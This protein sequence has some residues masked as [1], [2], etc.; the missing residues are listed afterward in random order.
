MRSEA[1]EQKSLVQSTPWKPPYR[2][3]HLSLSCVCCELDQNPE[4]VWEHR[5]IRTRQ[6]R[7]LENHHHVNFMDI[8][9]VPASYDHV[10]CLLHL[11]LVIISSIK[12]F[13]PDVEIA[14]VPS[15]FF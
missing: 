11:C 9:I 6:G 8:I 2:S 7:Y 4:G 12:A 3:L 14:Q 13:I 1:A 10:P 15:L 5:Q